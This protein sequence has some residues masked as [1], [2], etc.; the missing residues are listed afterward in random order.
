MNKK[1]LLIEDEKFIREVYKD[2]LESVG[3]LVDGFATGNEGLKAFKE[4]SYDLVVLDIILP[5]INGLH[6]LKEMKNDAVKKDTPVLIL[7]NADQDIV[8]RQG[9]ALG[10]EDYMQKVQ[11]TPDMIVDKINFIIDKK[12]KQK[13]NPPLS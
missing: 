1:L 5:D 12:S 13:E 7:S 11:S 6:V 2:E 8:I 3:F 4:N 9:L 10:A